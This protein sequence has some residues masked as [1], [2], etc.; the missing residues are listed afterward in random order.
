MFLIAVCRE[1]LRRRARITSQAQSPNGRHGSPGE[2]DCIRAKKRAAMKRKNGENK[3]TR[4]AD[5]LAV[6]DLPAARHTLQRPPHQ[7]E[8]T[9]TRAV[10]PPHDVKKYYTRK[11]LRSVA[12]A[13]RPP[14]HV[15]SHLPLT[16]ML[17]TMGTLTTTLPHRKK[18]R[19]RARHTPF[20][21]RC[22]AGRPSRCLE[23]SS[24]AAHRWSQNQPPRHPSAMYTSR[25]DPPTSTTRCRCRARRAPRSAR[26]PPAP[27]LSP[28]PVD[29]VRHRSAR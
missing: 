22:V 14:H 9:R 24:L 7:V 11:K 15:H 10:L 1:L 5:P 27:A 21:A 17:H 19:R 6:F 4:F 12:P 23:P 16:T 28:S 20:P 8:C 2:K 3:S 29:P 18:K 13:E 25:L 26:V